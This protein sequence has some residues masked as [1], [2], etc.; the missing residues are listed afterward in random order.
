LIGDFAEVDI[1][2]HL[3][4]I[5]NSEGLIGQ[6]QEKSKEQRRD[7]IPGQAESPVRNLLFFACGTNPSSSANEGCPR[8]LSA[9]VTF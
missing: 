9:G 6:R 5:S 1:T 7:V 2:N 3:C 8:A 4:K